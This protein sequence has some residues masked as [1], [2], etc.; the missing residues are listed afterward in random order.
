MEMMLEVALEVI[1]MEDNKMADMV[2][3]NPNEDFS[4]GTVAPAILVILMEM[5]L[6]VMM[7]VLDMDFDKVAQARGQISS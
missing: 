3:M 5:M 4:D 7:G 6:K 2:L 1:D